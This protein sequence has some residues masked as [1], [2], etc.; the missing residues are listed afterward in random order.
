M[1]KCPKCKSPSRHR[2]KRTGISKY[3]LGIKAYNCDHCNTRYIYIPFLN[4]GI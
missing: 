1:K 4:L 2:M 3:I